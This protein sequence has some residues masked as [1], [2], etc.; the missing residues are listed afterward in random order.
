MIGGAGAQR[1]ACL[2]ALAIRVAD[3][4][5]F[6]RNVVPIQNRVHL[7]RLSSFTGLT[8]VT[9]TWAETQ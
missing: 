6:E 3:P 4:I 2:F 1:G 9:N 5:G 7:F 8:T